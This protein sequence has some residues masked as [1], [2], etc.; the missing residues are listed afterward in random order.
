MSVV[1]NRL[2]RVVIFFLRGA[3]EELKDFYS[4]H[5]EVVPSPNRTEVESCADG[6]TSKLTNCEPI[7]AFVR[8]GTHF[9]TLKPYCHVILI[10]AATNSA[11]PFRQ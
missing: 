6:L 4:H 3:L 7:T 11:S 10:A 1:S 2:L 9:V 5:A 8:N